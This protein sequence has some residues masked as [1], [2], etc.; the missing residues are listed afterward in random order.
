MHRA[1]KPSRTWTIGKAMVSTKLWRR[2]LTYL[3][4]RFGSKAE[5]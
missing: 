3:Y 1:A 5:D 2:P 4:V